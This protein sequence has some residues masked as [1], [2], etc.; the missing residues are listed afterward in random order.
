MTPLTCR[1]LKLYLNSKVC[2][3][4]NRKGNS[5]VKKYQKVRDHCNFIGIQ[6]GAAHEFPHEIP[7]ILHNG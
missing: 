7:V 1:E 3:M 4:C 2:C 6:R 5:T